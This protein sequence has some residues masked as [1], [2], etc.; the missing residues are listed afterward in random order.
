MIFRPLCM[1]SLPK[2]K[3]NAFNVL[4]NNNFIIAFDDLRNDFL[5]LMQH[6]FIRKTNI[7]LSN[8][9]IFHHCLKSKERFLSFKNIQFVINR[10]LNYQIF[11]CENDSFFCLSNIFIYIMVKASFYGIQTM[12]YIC[13]SYF[14]IHRTLI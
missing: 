7:F 3:G 14:S 10:I 4:S 5:N 12:I 2:I 9:M 8:T 13:I 1:Q 6:L 11:F